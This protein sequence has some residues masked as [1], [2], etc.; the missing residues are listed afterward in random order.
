MVPL[1]GRRVSF[2]KKERAERLLKEVGLADRSEMR[3]LPAVRR[4]GE[5]QRVAIARAL[6][7]EP[8]WILA[9]EPTGNLDSENGE[10]IVRLLR[11]L[12]VQK[13]ATSCWSPMIGDWPS[14]RTG[15]WNCGRPDICMIRPKAG[16]SNDSVHLAQSLAAQGTDH[17]DAGRRVDR[18][19]GTR[20]SVSAVYRKAI[21]GPWLTCSRSAGR[22]PTTS[23]CA[24]RAPAGRDGTK[25]LLEPDYLTASAE[26]S[27][28]ISTRPSR[29][30]TVLKRRA[31]GDDR[32][33][34]L[35]KV[36]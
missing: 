36:C 34:T 14:R 22:L 7:N 4:E 3:L 28:L 29:G 30:L 26:E 1:L 15:D 32:L 13:G 8:D 33:C 12:N 25:H 27:V 21:P 20:L 18:Q 6:V 2:N 11:K 5:E 19:F 16:A 31:G 35:P 9:D 24:L 10:G 23:W 17:P